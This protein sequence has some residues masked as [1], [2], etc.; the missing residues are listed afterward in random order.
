[1]EWFVSTIRFD[2]QYTI[3]NK[4]NEIAE[5]RQ[6][7]FYQ[8]SAIRKVIWRK[9]LCTMYVTCE[10]RNQFQSYKRRSVSV[11]AARLLV[12]LNRE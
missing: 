4:P 6:M 2:S 3:F 9:I 11:R 1:M 12:Y 10:E 5:N 8:L 7:A